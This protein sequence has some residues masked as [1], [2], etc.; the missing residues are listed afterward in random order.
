M[1]RPVEHLDLATVIKVSQ[2]VSS[3]I[4]LENLI[5]TLLRTAI[6]Q[7]GAERAVLVI[8]RGKEPRIEAEASTSGHTVTVRVVE[9]AVTE[10]M[11]PESVLHYVLRARE[12]VILDDAAANSPYGVDP[13]IF[14]RQAR[15]ILCLP[16]LNQAKASARSTSKTT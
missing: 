12:I 16:L 10:R 1:F 7:A 2:A 14:L 4:V 15:S 6:E 8:Q 3:E 5:N 13:Y 9:E 11:L